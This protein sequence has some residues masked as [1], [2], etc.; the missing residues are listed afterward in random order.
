M[1]E[2]LQSPDRCQEAYISAEKE[3]KFPAVPVDSNQSACQ[4]RL[5]R[6]PRNSPLKVKSVVSSPF[7]FTDRYLKIRKDSL[8]HL[9]FCQRKAILPAFGFLLTSQLAVSSCYIARLAC[10]LVSL[11]VCHSWPANDSSSA[12]TGL[13]LTTGVYPVMWIIV[14][15]IWESATLSQLI[16]RDLVLH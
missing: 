10:K 7:F 8:H 3:N 14:C 4:E 2:M 6:H 9:H 16:W 5:V 13:R 15:R 12:E 11:L 1:N